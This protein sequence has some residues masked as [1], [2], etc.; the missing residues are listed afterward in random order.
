M[1]GENVFASFHMK[2]ALKGNIPL[3]NINLYIADNEY[4]SF[5]IIC[6][7]RI[8]SSMHFLISQTAEI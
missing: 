5:D 7:K 1:G 3:R 2:V 6:G 8:I 4:I